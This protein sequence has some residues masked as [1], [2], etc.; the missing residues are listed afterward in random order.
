VSGIIA[1]DA[2][3]ANASQPF[4]GVAP[5]ATLYMYRIFG[6]Q[7]DTSTDLIVDAMARAFTDG[8]QVISLSLGGDEGWSEGESNVVGQRIAAR[9]VFMS[10]AAG[11]SG[12][13]GIFDTSDPG[14]GLGSVAVASVDNIDLVSWNAVTGNGSTI[15]PSPLTDPVLT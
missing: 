4:T 5:G 15:V 12:A 14:S 7:G 10:V 1:A 3:N 13:D 6:C 2:R 9:G 8:A 11:N